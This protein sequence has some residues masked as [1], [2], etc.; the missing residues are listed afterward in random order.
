MDDKCAPADGSD[1]IILEI[2]IPFLFKK[3]TASQYPLHTSLSVCQT[4][5]TLTQ[6]SP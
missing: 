1:T 2:S 3:S 5:V 6:D 4:W